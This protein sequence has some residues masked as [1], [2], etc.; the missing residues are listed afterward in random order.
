MLDSVKPYKP[1]KPIAEVERE[2]GLK[3]VVKLASNENPYGPSEKAVKAIVEAAKDVNRYPDGGCFY[4]KEALG[5]KLD[6]P[7]GNIVFGNG[8][9][10]LIVMALSAYVNSGDEV[11]V[12]DPTFLVYHIASMVKGASVRSV[13]LKNF[14]YDIDG[15]ISAVNK[16]TKII[17][18]VNPDNPTGS[19]ITSDE[20]KRLVASIPPSVLIFV[21]EAYYEFACGD[22]YPESLDWFKKGLPNIIIARTFSKA[23]GLAGLRIG[24]AIAPKEIIQIL[25]KVR[26]PFNVNSVAQAAA[27]AALDD[28]EYVKR[29]VDLVKKEKKRFYAFFDSLKVKYLFSKSNFILVNTERDS[30]KFF[31]HLLKKG[32]IVREMSSWGLMGFIRVNVGSEKENDIFFKAFASVIE[33]TSKQ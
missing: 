8:S 32:V 4:L 2:L 26:E 7:G 29:S 13:P 24:Y 5:R 6:V 27:L 23:Y 28:E 3:G 25:N 10:E 18:I 33:G 17:F 1:G 16:N 15:M 11:V 19:Y 21:D 9:D 12:A 14:K 30:K 20:F 31:E 22:D